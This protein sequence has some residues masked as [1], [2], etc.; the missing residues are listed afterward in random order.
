MRRP[1]AP[2]SVGLRALPAV[3]ALL[4]PARPLAL[5]PLVGRWRDGPRLA[6]IAQIYRRYF[7]RE[8]DDARDLR[9][10]APGV[11]ALRAAVERL[12]DLIEADD[13]LPIDPNWLDLW[14]VEGRDPR[15]PHGDDGARPAYLDD[16]PLDLGHGF[17]HEGWLATDGRSAAEI[18]L[19]EATGAIGVE[20]ALWAAVAA[21]AP[22]LRRR[23]RRVR[24]RLSDARASD[25]VAGDAA[26]AF[27]A[28]PGALR[29][30][31]TFVRFLWGETGNR[32]L[33]VDP[34]DLSRCCDLPWRCEAF[35]AM[36]EEWDAAR[37][38]L[39]RVGDVEGALHGNLVPVLAAIEATLGTL[40]GD[41]I[42]HHDKGGQD[43]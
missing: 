28:L 41:E 7:P 27:A 14:R 18:L 8:W 43:R 42:T 34:G 11:G 22:R 2:P 6:E 36:A 38:T 24:E 12:I 29:D 37:A 33:D 23:V 16:L 5:G 21:E 32:F 20:G 19:G 30:I 17:D 9:D 40:D 26:G 35:R 1:D 15:D 31:P 4:A 39:A 3:R 13:L 10:G 25:R